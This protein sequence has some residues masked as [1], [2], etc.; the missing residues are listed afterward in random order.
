MMRRVLSFCFALSFSVAFS[1]R[2]LVPPYLQPGNAPSLSRE[3]KVVIWQTDS[4]QG[5]FTVQYAQGG[6]LEG[7][8]KL[9]MAKIDAQPL[10]FFGRT[11]YLYRAQLTGLNFDADYTYRVSLGEQVISAATFKTRTKTP[12]V[13]FVAMGDVG[14]ASPQQKAVAYQVYQAK[15][16]FVLATGDLAYNNGLEREYRVR[17]F[18]PYTTAEA[19]KDKGAPLMQSVPFYLFAGNH[20]FYGADLGKFP[21]GMAI[22]YY[23][24]SPLNGPIT[25]FTTDVTGPPD[26]VKAFKKATDGR[27]PKMNNY[28]FED[29]NVHI[30]VL[31]ANSYINPLDPALVEWMRRDIGSSKAD[32]KIVSYHHPGFN[33]SKAHY[34]YQ[35][36]RLL[37]PLLEE[38]GVNLVITSH[39]HNYQRSKPIK[40]AP[41][42]NESGDHYVVSPEGRVDG[43]FTLDEKFDGVTQTKPEGIIYVISG[44]GGAALYDPVMSNKPET[45]VHEPAANWV[46]YTVKL[47]SDIHSFTL[48]E[49]N[50]KQLSLKQIDMNGGLLDEIT[51]TK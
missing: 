46:P 26:R 44:S 24:D 50:G 40:F 1:Q 37:S 49:T 35:Q 31:D 47:I 25:Q 51:I 27:F 9:S 48:V 18:P 12:N 8:A 41:K 7:V 33:S 34:D 43:K 17:F 29:G 4:V 32:W 38:L 11:T 36:M 10:V 5:N 39:V 14:T 20:D 45:W 19:A 28:S 16:Q 21:D 23:A 2:I 3:M 42:L 30:T 15:P 13:R 6:T 22:F